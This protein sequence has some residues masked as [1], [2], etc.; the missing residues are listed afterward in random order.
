MNERYNERCLYKDTYIIINMMGNDLKNRINPKF[1]E[2]LKENQDNEYESCINE[3][4]PLKKQELREE[5]KLMLS[6]I[7]IN[8]LCESSE[9]ENILK[10][11]DNNIKKYN[12]N[13]YGNIFKKKKENR[14]E[15]SNMQLVVV[16]EKNIIQKM[17]NKIK[18]PIGTFLKWLK[19]YQK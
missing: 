7:Y 18:E 6:I 19:K 4:L 5:I 11:E 17:I 9:R 2:F 12:E 10:E 14:Y 13:I 15:D 1:I 16:K 3:K 8:Y